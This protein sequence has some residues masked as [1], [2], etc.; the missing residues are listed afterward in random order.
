M[1]E[2]QQTWDELKEISKEKAF[3]GC[4]TETALGTID[5][6]KDWN[7]TKEE[8][9]RIMR[10]ATTAREVIKKLQPIIAREK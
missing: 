9:F 10:E 7:K 4:V 1:T 8:V 3:P 2:F 5:S 6:A